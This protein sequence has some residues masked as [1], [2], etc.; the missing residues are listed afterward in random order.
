MP[1]FGA[2]HEIQPSAISSGHRVTLPTSLVDD[3]LVL[4]FDVSVSA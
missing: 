4:E 2:P 1:A 3:T